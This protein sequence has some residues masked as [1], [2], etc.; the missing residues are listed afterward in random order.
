MHSFS[1]EEKSGVYRAIHQ[2]RDVRKEFLS[3]R[4]SKRIL[5]KIFNAAH[6]A[7]SV[8][9]MQP[10]NFVVINDDK[11]K[12]KIK[13]IFLREHKR[14]KEN[15]RGK[16]KKLYSSLK[17]E[18]IEESPVNVCITCDSKRGGNHVLGRN[19]IKET[20]IFSTCCAIQNL[21]LAARAEGIGVGWVSIMNNALLKKTLKIPKHIKP[22]AYLCM[23]YVSH[24]AN[25]PLLE[26]VGWRK[27]LVLDDLVSWNGWK[28]IS[29]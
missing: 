14:A 29:K 4:I 16:Q 26:S 12:K 24:F 17:L 13:A 20:D 22:V 27:R 28:G 1:K 7:G 18:G 5:M 8:G 10:W 9:F 11:I 2:R 3:K 6:H 15:Y 21:W 25:K 19:T 23:G